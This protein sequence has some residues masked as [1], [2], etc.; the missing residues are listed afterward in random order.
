MISDGA[1]GLTPRVIVQQLDQYIV[2]QDRAKRAV[3]VAMR[4]RWRR[5]Q[6]PEDLRQD[7]L[8]K[9]IIMIGPTGVGKTE[10]ARRLAGL[11]NAPFIKVEA[12]HYTEV[13]YHGRDVESMVRELVELSMNMVRAEM[14]EQVRPQAEA[15]AEERL[16]DALYEPDTSAETDAERREQR[17]RARRRLRRLLGEGRL[18]DRTVE[19]E[20]S[21]KPRVQG[22]AIGGEEMG[23]DMQSMLEEMLPT[24]VETRHL[25]VAEARAVLVRQESE[26]L[27]DKQAVS[28]TA[29]WRAENNGII[30]ID[31]LDKVASSGS[32]THGPDV[33]REGVQRDLLPVVEGC[34]VPTRYGM[35]HTDHV[36]F[37]AAGAFTVAKPSD[38][39]PEL[40]GRFPI[41][42]ELDDLT[43]DDFIR[44]LREPRTALT[45]Q[46]RALLATEGLDLEF[47]D[48]AV[49]RVAEFAE[50]INQ[51]G[52]S[53]GARRLQTVM[54][55]LLE[56]VS[57]DA[58]EMTDRKLT[59]DRDYVEGRLAELIEDEDLT[60]Y[61]L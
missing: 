61:I 25:T 19:I 9:N 34:S 29:I 44:I 53:I 26:R 38:L 1:K 13:G 50:Q 27:V 36:L 58:P 43:K 31:E 12:S 41:R 20:V 24:R 18:D 7:I 56:D 59:V 3:A 54:E 42:V 51:R 4:N 60:R 49:E 30:F 17:G 2:G 16:L 39:I 6:V 8:P 22:M 57:F 35:V 11:A 37:V 15:N 28:R 14:G 23:V 33:S 48:E 40:Q 21:E 5:Q 47:T 52:Q 32:Q 10:I 45:K 55:K 46:Y